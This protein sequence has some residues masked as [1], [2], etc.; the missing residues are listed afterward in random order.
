M[1]EQGLSIGT[2]CQNPIF[3]VV[4]TKTLKRHAHLISQTGWS[5]SRMNLRLTPRSLPALCTLWRWSP[6]VE[7]AIKNGPMI[8]LLCQYPS[9][10]D[11][12]ISNAFISRNLWPHFFPGSVLSDDIR[13]KQMSQIH[14]SWINRLPVHIRNTHLK[15]ANHERKLQPAAKGI[16]RPA[17]TAVFLVHSFSFMTNSSQ[18]SCGQ[19]RARVLKRE[20]TPPVGLMMIEFKSQ[21]TC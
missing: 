9:S 6:Q 21:S 2:K 10:S 13:P 15:F 19:L 17:Y 12:S 8:P 11:T 4:P 18:T 7:E 5:F 16:S 14:L 1:E 3:T 20:Q